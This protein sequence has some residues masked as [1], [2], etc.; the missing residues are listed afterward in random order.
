MK[1]LLKHEFKIQ[2]VTVLIFV[3]TFVKS[4]YSENGIFSQI[5]IV[6]FFVLAIVQYTLNI[7]KFFNDDFI[8]DDSRKLYMFLS[9]FV[10]VGFLSWRL[11]F[12]FD[13]SDFENFS[14]MLALTWIF[15]TPFLIFQSLY[16]SWSD[17]EKKIE[18][19]DEISQK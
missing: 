3:V 17:S 10:V 9:I 2:I 15:L 11:A 6:E 16:I 5:M 12:V 14:G 18:K 8:N 13:W 7:I 19:Q 1:T 4:F